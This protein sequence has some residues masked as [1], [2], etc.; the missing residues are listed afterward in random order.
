M[1]K[2]I[3]LVILAVLIGCGKSSEKTS[4]EVMKI[5]VE[6]FL[7]KAAELK[8]KKVEITGMVVHTCRHG[9][10]RAH[11]VGTEPEKRIKLEVVGDAPKF[12]KELEGKSILAEG[13]VRQLIIDEA[14]LAKW[15]NDIK[16]SGE[17]DK[18]LHE[19]HKEEHKHLSE[20]EENLTKIDKY[21][22]QLKESGKEKLEFYWIDCTKYQI[23][24]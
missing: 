14:Y 15:E 22:K 6:D 16:V 8:D 4:A 3:G 1:K 13:I 18:N 2:L 17:S 24:G 7:Q 11:I 20:Q 23:K 12:E 9:G 5:S 10:K 21:R 19:G